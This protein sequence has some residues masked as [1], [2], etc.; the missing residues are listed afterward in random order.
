MEITINEGLSW[1]KTLRARHSE[2]VALRNQNADMETRYYGV[3]ASRMSEKKPLYDVKKLDALIGAVA[4]DI[5][6]LDSAIKKTN[7]TTTIVGYSQ[8]EDVLG[9]VE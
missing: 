6:L 1:M 3:D 4:R 7:V 5:R 8:N 9:V 2:L